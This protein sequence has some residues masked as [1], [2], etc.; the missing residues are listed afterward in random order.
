MTNKEKMEL[1]K[2]VLIGT[3][4]GVAGFIIGRK[5]TKLDNNESEIKYLEEN[6]A[7]LESDNFE[8]EDI[9]DRQTLKIKEHIDTINSLKGDVKE[10]DLSIM[11]LV[12]G[13]SNRYRAI[14]SGI[15][16]DEEILMNSDRLDIETLK[17]KRDYDVFV[18]NSK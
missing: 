16:N 11:E 14:R 10:R 6:I 15:W 8:L 2:K 7:C 13:E 12:D 9:I 4:I 3:G 17:A 5:M 18:R 1:A